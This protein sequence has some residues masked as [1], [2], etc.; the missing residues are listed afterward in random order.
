MTQPIA[1]PRGAPTQDDLKKLG[2]RYKKNHRLLKAED[3]EVRLPLFFEF[4]GSPKTGKSSIIG[5]VAHFLK[6]QGVRVVQPAEGA[7]LRTPQPLKDDLLAFNAWSGC[8][9]LQNILI[10]SFS[11]CPTDVVLLD[12]GLFDVAAWMDYLHRH[13]R[14]ITEEE[15]D[16]AEQFFAI[17]LWQRRTNAVFL[18]TSDYA[19]SLERE[20]DSKLTSVPGSVM[21]AETLSLLQDAYDQTRSRRNREFNRVFH[22][23]TS[24]FSD[25]THPTF[26]MIA[27]VV[28]EKMVDIIEELATQELLVTRNVAFD[29][30][31]TSPNIIEET[32]ARI[33]QNGSPEFVPREQAE[34]SDKYQQVVPYAVLR[35][36]DGRYFM[37]RRR[38]DLKRK[39]LQKKLTILVG[40]HAEKK[41]WNSATP[42]AVFETC[43]RRELEEELCGIRIDEIRPLGFVHDP[44]TRVGALHLAFVHEVTVGGKV[45]VRRQ[46]IDKEFGREPVTWVTKD[47]IKNKMDE[48]D[49]WSQLVA[50]KLLDLELPPSGDLFRQG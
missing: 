28:A 7:S 14:R 30:F 35:N 12:R 43:L 36:A 11:E 21:N 47:D 24:F 40:G 10:D 19:T 4:S 29:G 3:S 16:V 41:D 8:Y 15:R 34:E 45:I 6:R 31:E 18:F 46:A 44:H 22:I 50:S 23:D 5:I 1:I 42:E 26:Q 17:D 13:E 49:P 33:L 38:A 25:G 9:A 48:L 37:A 20:T 2:I 39:E 32:K 27:Y